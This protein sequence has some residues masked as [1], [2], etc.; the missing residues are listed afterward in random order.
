MRPVNP[1][2]PERPPFAWGTVAAITIGG[3]V[4]H[5]FAL[6]HYG[7]FRDEL[8]YLVCA[9]HPAWGYV[10]QPPL[11]IAFL[12]LWRAVFG[13][14]LVAVRVAP[15]LCHLGAALLGAAIAREM[16]GGRYAQGM[17]A[18]AVL[19]TPVY[20]AI[21][22]FFSMNAIDLVMWEAAVLLVMV[23]L[24]TGGTRVWVV[25]GVVLGLGL[26][27]KISVLWL[28]LGLGAGL[29]LT[30]YR[31][32]LRTRGPWLAV[33]IAVLLFAPHVAWQMRHGWPTL[34]F[35]RNA[36]GQKMVHVGAL[37]FV[38][39]QLLQMNPLAAPLWITGLVWLLVAR[40]ARPWRILGI[41]FVVVAV[42]LFAA[43]SSR[44]SYLSL[45]YPPLLA[46]GAVALERAT[47]STAWRRARVPAAVLLAVAGLLAAPLALPVL[48][49]ERYIAYARAVGIAPSTEE[50][51]RVGPLPQHYADMFGWAELVDT[52]ARAYAS[53]SPEERAHCGIFAQ[54][55]GEAGA[56]TVLGR[57]RGLPPAMSGHNNFWLWGPQAERF[58]PVIIVGGDPE[59]NAQV[60][61]RLEPAG[62]VFSP[63]QMPY[64]QHRAVSIGRGLKIPV[65][66]LWP[67]LKH[68]I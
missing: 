35:M 65:H 67:K 45:A 24:R 21:C 17:A 33:A 48:P 27:N 56:I 64:E 19:L 63:Y 16:H 47:A 42:V 14:S 43:G 68:F 5:L 44:A 29:V 52:V 59:D 41:V 34:E 61:E 15:V 10:D 3:L 54:N 18:L 23:A 50:H 20:L 46:A 51:Q 57:A 4:L 53:L 40:A 28:G 9:D 8:Y 55:Y 39:K 25:L 1:S 36:A 32:V 60:F 49:V 62:E 58:D 2:A 26:L 7:W 11:S 38:R 31:A 66:E 13:G 12:A 37:D 30:P 22:H 6:V